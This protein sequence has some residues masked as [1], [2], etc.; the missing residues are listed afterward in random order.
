MFTVNARRRLAAIA[1]SLGSSSGAIEK[2]GNTA[3]AMFGGVPM[4][5]CED[6]HH[7][8]SPA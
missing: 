4:F 8:N 5:R 2:K 7:R 6:I 3:L 1:K